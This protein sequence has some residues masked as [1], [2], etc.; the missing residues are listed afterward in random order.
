MRTV[1]ALLVGLAVVSTA[2]AQ[3]TMIDDFESYTLG[4]AHMQGGW[5]IQ[6]N[7]S[8]LGDPG[9]CLI[10][11][12]G[13]GNKVIDLMNR[14]L[15]GEIDTIY[16]ALDLGVSLTGVETLKMTVRSNGPNDT[17]MCTNALN[18]GWYDDG[19]GDNDPAAGGQG[20]TDYSA[21]GMMI[22]VKSD[23]LFR[24]RDDGGYV[25]VPQRMTSGVWYD[26]YMVID[27]PN[28]RTIYA[29][30]P[31]GATVGPEHVVLDGTGSKWWGHRNDSYSSVENLKFMVGMFPY[32]DANIETHV[33]I[34]NIMYMEGDGVPEPAT[35]SLL[36]LGGLALIRRRR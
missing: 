15:D 20:M 27:S 10:V 26:L 29:V 2:S 36:A 22:C 30:A 25:N 31:A 3:Y 4:T 23:D 19:T 7:S 28:D 12:D 34:D 21:Q 5:Q 17:L 32:P 11:D 35:M 8:A 16:A 18:P 33:Q 14:D 1:T 13:T 9:S 6:R 24:A